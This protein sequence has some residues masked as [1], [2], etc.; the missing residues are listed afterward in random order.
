MWET[1]VRS[2]GWEDP[3]EKGMATHSSTL[4]WK[5]PWTG[6]PGGLQSMESQ[7]TAHDW[8]T[9][10]LLT[11]RFQ[12]NEWDETKVLSAN[13]SYGLLS[14]EVGNTPDRKLPWAEDMGIEWAYFGRDNNKDRESDIDRSS[15]VRTHYMTGW[16]GFHKE[17]QTEGD[18][19]KV[20]LNWS[21]DGLG[22]QEGVNTGCEILEGSNQNPA[23]R[24]YS[25]CWRR[26]DLILNI[27]QKHQEFQKS[28]VRSREADSEARREEM[29]LEAEGSGGCC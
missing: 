20:A 13:K 1:Q 7:R 4:T 21:T 15:H 28:R 25:K 24:G 27:I 14:T 10:L 2:P 5:T 19:E 17:G 6:E 18:A 8:A 22:W 29:L 16:V 26:N 9:S 12:Y 23:N 11:V 3:L